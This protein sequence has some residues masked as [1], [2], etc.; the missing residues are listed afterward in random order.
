MEETG[1][2]V[3]FI[4][5]HGDVTEKEFEKYYK[6]KIDKAVSLN[7]SFLICDY[8]GADTLAQDYLKN[9]NKVTVFHMFENPRY[10]ANI[11]WKTIGGFQ[12]DL[13]RDSYGT[14]NSNYDIYFVRKGREK[15][16]TMNNV[17]RRFSNE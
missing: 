17:K 12:T 15:S 5:G 4:F 2:K 8:K 13:E 9:Y 6:F 10:K 3:V 14:F 16:G 11:S 7:Y 1:E